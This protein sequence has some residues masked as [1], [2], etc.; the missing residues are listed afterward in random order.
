MNA[1]WGLSPCGR[2][3]RLGLGTM[4]DRGPQVRAFQNADLAS[5]DLT[6]GTTRPEADLGVA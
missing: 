6:T 3:G 2:R 1:C 4:G 5:S